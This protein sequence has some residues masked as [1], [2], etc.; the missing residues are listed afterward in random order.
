MKATYCAPYIRKIETGMINKFGRMSQSNGQVLETIDG[1]NVDRL[2]EQ[3]GSPLFVFSEKTMRKRFQKMSRAFTSLY[4]G[5]TFGWSYKTNYLGAIC[6]LFHQEGAAAEVVSEMEYEKARQLGLSG[7]SIIFN[8]PGKSRTGLERAAMDKA[9]IHIDHFDE[10]YLLE[11]IAKKLGQKIGVGLRINMD[12]GVYPQW[13][14]FGF[15]L[16]SGQAMAA[17]QRI[18]DK[19]LLDLNGLHTHMGTYILEP[20]AYG[21]AV[22]K[23]MDFSGKAEKRFGFKTGYIDLGGGFPSKSRLKGI[24]HSPDLTVPPI[25][26]Y[27]GA[28]TQ[29]LHD[30]AKGGDLPE[31]VLESGRSMIDSAGYLISTILASKRMPD[32]RK[33]YVADAGVNLLPTSQWY[34]HRIRFD[35]EIPGVGEPSVIYGPLCMNIDVLDE[36]V[37]LPALKSGTRMIFSPVGAYNLT[38]WMQFIQFR[39][40]VVLIGDNKQI[41]V[42]REAEDLSDIIRRERLPD[43]LSLKCSN[44]GSTY[45]SN[46][47]SGIV[48]A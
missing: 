29:A 28:I 8:G 36:S 26:D 30:C 48:A 24:Y 7:R 4:P 47:R 17:A 39:P 20:V 14:R 23:L 37:V 12:T 21:R 42:I 11:E 35:R 31:L 19:G 25:E 18:K 22:E 15:N 5:V 1:V 38:Q 41:D 27:A 3:F 46:Y 13:S 2:V 40:A 45:R 9:R 34:K 33:A 32:G 16:E 43:R 6:S 10:L 44:H